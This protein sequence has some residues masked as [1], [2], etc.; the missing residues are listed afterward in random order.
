MPPPT[1][2]RPMH[3]LPVC[4]GLPVARHVGCLF[5]CLVKSEKSLDTSANARDTIAVLTGQS[6]STGTRG[7]TDEEAA[8]PSHFVGRHAHSG[9]RRLRQKT[10][11][12]AAPPAA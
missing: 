4:E 2:C 11:V 8:R 6:F 3:W 5:N 9:D 7:A 12:S 10:G 1:S